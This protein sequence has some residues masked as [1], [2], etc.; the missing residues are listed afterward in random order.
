MESSHLSLEEVLLR[1]IATS[2]LPVGSRNARAALG[3]AGRHVS[4]ATVSRALRR[5]D[6]AGLTQSTDGKGRVAT[7]AGR[8]RVAS[9]ASVTKDDDRL[10]EAIVVR[11]IDDLLKLLVARRGVEREA[12]RHAAGNATDDDVRMLRSLID[13][14]RSRIEAGMGPRQLAR[15]FHLAIGRL[16]GNK[17]IAAMTELVFDPG[18]DRVEGILDVIVGS[19]HTEARSLDEHA[20]IVSAIEARDEDGAEATMVDHL[21]RLLHETRAYASPERAELVDRVLDWALDNAAPL[22]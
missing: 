10:R 20:R 3:S 1:V 14:Q 5:L 6:E 16:S 12:A 21:N 8:Q 11:S 19:H 4:E 13:D 17:L 2:L 22:R 9:A 15:E 7:A 18:L